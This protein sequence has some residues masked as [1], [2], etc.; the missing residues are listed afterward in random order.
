MQKAK[1]QEIVRVEAGAWRRVMSWEEEP[2]LTLSLRWPKLPEEPPGLRRVGRYYRRLSEQ[3]KSRWEGELYRRACSGAAAAR[4][5]SRPFRPWTAALDF[6][7]TC[8]EPGLLSLC[9]DAVEDP[10]AARPVTLRQG[11]VWALPSGTI[12]TPE[13]FF[14]PRRRWRRQVLEA[15]AAQIRARTASG[16]ALFC[17]DWP[18]RLEREFS[19][20]RFYVEDGSLVFF[21]PLCTIAPYF[22]GIPT[23]C[24]P[25]PEVLS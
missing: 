19:P 20:N 14:P 12:R 24:I 4:E 9:L 3:W 21:Y 6:R 25:K 1:E 18:H 5:A 10:G 23:F 17:A 16:E 13:S 15:A 22:E 7:I 11:D 8:Q 2:V